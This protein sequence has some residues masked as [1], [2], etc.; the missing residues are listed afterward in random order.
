MSD[1]GRNLTG[2]RTVDDFIQRVVA[3]ILGAFALGLLLGKVL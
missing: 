2:S 1:L 3:M